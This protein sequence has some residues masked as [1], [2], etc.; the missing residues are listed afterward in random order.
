MRKS[1]NKQRGWALYEVLL[2]TAVLVPLGMLA[3]QKQS[4]QF[5]EAKGLHNAERT[6]DFGEL[7][8]SYYRTN[9]PALRAA[10]AD[11]TGAETLCRLGVD[12]TAAQPETTGIQSN[13]LSLH[14]CAID[15]S[16]L[17]W[18]GLAQPSFPEFNLQQQHMV[19]IFR[20]VYDTTVDPA[21]PTDNVEMLN[22][23]ASGATGIANYAPNSIG[24]TGSIDPLVRDA[25][26]M[27]ASG[28]VIPDAD[29]VLCKWLD[30][31]PAQ[32]EACG[33]QGGWRVNLS[34]FV[35]S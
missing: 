7:A 33:A 18:K 23:G 4:A 12:P 1:M 6:Q 35:G 15:T 29:R 11:G 20:R 21:V 13:S 14:T 26:A 10:M 2:A 3:L 34:D 5:E 32:R 16:V 31:D 25:K 22:V 28:G 30:S 8:L 19:A 27:G 24:F 17:K 9:A